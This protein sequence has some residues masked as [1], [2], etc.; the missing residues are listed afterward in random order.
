MT[1]Q[2]LRAVVER[3]SRR[4]GRHPLEVLALFAEAAERHLRQESE[5]AQQVARYAQLR[6]EVTEEIDACLSRAAYE[7]FA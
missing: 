4:T 1:Q 3:T 5:D 2:Q 7:E 6:R